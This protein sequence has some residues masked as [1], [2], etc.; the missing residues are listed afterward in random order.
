MS[1]YRAQVKWWSWSYLL[2]P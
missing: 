2:L 1:L